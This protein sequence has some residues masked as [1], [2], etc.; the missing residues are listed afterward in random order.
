MLLLYVDDILLSGSDDDHV[1]QAVETLK[2]MFETMHLGDADF[3]QGMGIHRNLHAGTI[4]LSQETYVRTILKTYG[5]ADAHPTK[6]PAEAGPV[7]IQEECFFCQQ[8]TPHY[9]G[10]PR[11]LFL[12]LIHI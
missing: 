6:P 12:S 5:M 4:S 9:S 3:L 7:L 1:M 10:L 11:D 8:K 2:D